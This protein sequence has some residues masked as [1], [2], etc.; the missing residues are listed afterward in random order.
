MNLSRYRRSGDRRPANR[1]S[2]GDRLLG[3]RNAAPSEEG[4]TR[5]SRLRLWKRVACGVV[6]IALL[7]ASNSAYATPT[8]ED[9]A[10]L[11]GA[12][13]EAQVVEPEVNP[14]DL[15]GLFAEVDGLQLAFPLENTATTAQI[16]GNVARVEVRQ[17][18][19]NPYDFPLEAVY[20]FPLPENAAV[21]EM[22]IQIG[23]LIVRGEIKERQEAQEI[24][25]EAVAAGQTAA[26][27]EQERP[28]IFTQSLANIVPGESIDAVIRYSQS[29]K[30]EGGDYEFVFPMVVGPR[31]IPGEPIAGYRPGQSEEGAGSTD[32]IPDYSQGTDRVPDAGRITPPMLPPEVR[33][34]HDIQVTVNIDAGVA[35]SEVRSP[36]HEIVTA[37]NDTNVQLR[38]RETVP[39]KDFILRYRVAGDTTQATLLSQADDR[40]GHFAAYLI[41]A[42]DYQPDEIAPK[43]VVFL[44]DT[45]GSQAGPPI[46]QSKALMREF[47][48]RLNPDD[49]FTVINFSNASQRLS[50]RPLANTR[51][52][53]M[54]ALAYINL[55]RADGGTQLMNGIDT[56]LNFPEAEDGRLRSI[57][58][59]TDGLIGNDR[60]AIAAIRDR[61][62]PGN[63]IYTFGVGSSTNRFLL[64]RLAEV[65]RGKAEILPPSEPAE[66][67]AEAFV[68]TINNPVLTNIEV[69]WEGSG[70]PPD[71]YPQRPTDLFSSQ[72]LVLYGRKEDAT[73]GTLVVSGDL[74][75][76]DRYRQE[77]QV[78]FDEPG[79]PAIAQLWGRARIR[80]LNN[81][82]FGSQLNWNSPLSD[83][84]RERRVQAITD[85]ALNYNLLSDYTAFVAV[86]EE[87]RVDPNDPSIRQR[88]PVETPEGMQLR[89]RRNAE[90][91]EFVY[92]SPE[93]SLILGNLLALSVLALFL[94]RPDK[95]A[96][97]DRP[98]ESLG[99]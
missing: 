13:A 53:R 62:Q 59:L 55:L 20:Q 21:D 47:L 27:L 33:S 38:D 36:S 97:G 72:P 52:N 26:L 30:F 99:T 42:V 49:T 84:D 87:I 41:P 50:R 45:S 1:R 80:D 54:R 48:D 32:R 10:W 65:G 63:R 24:Y 64:E 57:V 37:E 15:G 16:S 14:E 11:W 44:L 22:E 89:D 60:E 9:L 91:P 81:Q 96:E 86:T 68:R 61:L 28:N 98:V 7:V 94:W 17:T 73:N 95:K 40:G 85:T 23:D 75:G 70:D 69:T 92:A 66:V 4:R 29:L 74:P 83:G 90:Q 5:L 2:R 76:G 12:R 51:A 67:V 31:F 3:D 8:A 79:N 39:N 77:L 93:P 35:I 88:V 71:I 82:L 56:V 46:L 43:D 58:L 6:A 19:T 25:E 78:N 18:F 34:G